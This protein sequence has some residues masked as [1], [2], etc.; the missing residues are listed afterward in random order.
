VSPGWIAWAESRLVTT[1]CEVT[2]RLVLTPTAGGREWEDVPAHVATLRAGTS[3]G[4]RRDLEWPIRRLSEQLHRHLEEARGTP[5]DRGDWVTRFRLSASWNGDTATVVVTSST[6]R[7][8]GI[9]ERTRIE[10]SGDPDAVARVLIDELDARLIHPLRRALL[11]VRHTGPI[12]AEGLYE[13]PLSLP[14]TFRTAVLGLA[15]HG[16]EA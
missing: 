2:S 3:G 11:D 14:G 16:D 7:K 12:P 10:V 4:S 13:G 5:W 15:P 6:R 8:I 9:E 1:A